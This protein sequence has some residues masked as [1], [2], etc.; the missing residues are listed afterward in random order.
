MEKLVKLVAASVV[1]GQDGFLNRWLELLFIPNFFS[2]S[3]NFVIDRVN[4]STVQY[5]LLICFDKHPAR[6]ELMDSPQYFYERFKENPPH[7]VLLDPN[8]VWSSSHHISGP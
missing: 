5:C 8:W 7:C 3:L 1:L 2:L 6:L 4:A